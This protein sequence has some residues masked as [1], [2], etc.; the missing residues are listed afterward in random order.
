MQTLL[1]LELWTSTSRNG[2]FLGVLRTS[3]SR[4]AINGF[5]HK[6]DLNLQC[7]S[8]I[9]KNNNTNYMYV[10]TTHTHTHIYI[11]ICMY[12]YVCVCVC[13]CVCV[14]IYIY[15][16]IY[17]TQTYVYIYICI[18]TLHM[19]SWKQLFL[20]LHIYYIIKEKHRKIASCFSGFFYQ[21]HFQQFKTK[22]KCYYVENKRTL[23]CHVIVTVFI[24]LV[25][26][27][28]GRPGKV[29]NLN[30]RK[31]FTVLGKL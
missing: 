4:T 10:H 8:N 15:I 28:F 9:Y 7:L 26:R 31:V 13:V 17:V 30:S 21:L 1:K 12:A 24:L 29:S 14:H 6:W 2:I 11:Y 22:V 25:F 16:Y 18:Y 27:Y 19:Q 3:F 20:W 5:F 23:T